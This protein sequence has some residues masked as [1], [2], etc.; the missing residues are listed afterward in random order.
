MPAGRLAGKV[1]I[2]T[3]TSPNIG[4]GI[5]E[6]LAAAEA[7]VVC[8]DRDAANAVDCA[9]AIE[10]AGGRAIARTCDVR[11]EDQVRTV[12]A[13]A[14][15]AFGSVDVLVNGV[16][17]YNMKG[18]REMSLAEFRDQVD[19]ILCGVFVSTKVA[20]EAMIDGGRGGSIIHI[21]STEA[22]QGNPQNVAY[23]TAKAGLLNMARSNAMELVSYGIRVNTLTPTATDPT[24]SAERAA[25]WGRPKPDVSGHLAF[26][27]MRLLPT[28]QGP[29]PSDYGAAAVFLASDESRFVTG[30]DLRVDAGAIARYWGWGDGTLS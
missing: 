16:A 25:R 5:A 2:V 27:R 14:V 17:Y 11:D 4:G 9:R 12:V 22:H 13:D 10:T 15:G 18:I 19:L 26:R 24:E 7:A 3:G 30:T 28:G 21:A 29:S 1:A 23:T 20:A 8:V 6:A